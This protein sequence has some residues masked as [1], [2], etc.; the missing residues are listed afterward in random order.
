[1]KRLS[2]IMPDVI[3]ELSRAMSHP[4]GAIGRVEECEIEHGHKP[5]RYGAVEPISFSRVYWHDG[6]ITQGADGKTIRIVMI[7]A[8]QPRNGALTRMLREISDKGLTPVIVA[9]MGEVMCGFL[10]RH[11]WKM[12]IVGEGFMQRDEWSPPLLGEV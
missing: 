3:A 11:D 1:M 4:R 12:T 5:I 10:R 8:K 9:P 2:D 6:V 7:A